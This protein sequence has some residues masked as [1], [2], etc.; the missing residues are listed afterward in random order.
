MKKLALYP[1]GLPL[2][3]VNEADPLA[4][5]DECTLC[6]LHD[7]VRRVCMGAEG[8]RGGILVV[9]ERPTKLEDTAG[10][11][12]YGQSGLRVR[13]MMEDM[14]EKAIPITYDYAIKCH[15]SALKMNDK[16][17][18]AC[19]SYMAYTLRKTKPTRI[20]CM[21]TEAALSVLGRRI[22]TAK[23]RRAYGW[24]HGKSGPIPVFVLPPPKL[25]FQNPFASKAFRQDL[26]WALEADVKPWFIDAVTCL[27]RTKADARVAAKRL[28]RSAWYAYDVETYGRMHN[29]N[30]R[31]EAVTLL[32]H[33]ASKSYTWTREALKDPGALSVLRDLMRDKRLRAATQNGK[34]DDRSMLC[35]LGVAPDIYYDTRLGRKLL[36]PEASASLDHLA[37]TVGMGGHKREAQAKN[38]I[39]KRELNRLANPPSELTPKG[40]RRKIKPPMF[41]VD[42]RVL[43]DIRG[44]IDPDAFMYGF[45]EDRVLYRY[46]ARDVWSTREVTVQDMPVLEKHPTISRAWNLVV[47]DANKAIRRIEH[48]GFPVD[49]DAVEHLASYC[50]QGIADLDDKMREYTDINPASTKQLAEYLYE[51]LDLPCQKM[52]PSGARST[53]EEALEEL[54]SSH[55]YVD[56]LLQRRKL[57]KFAGTYAR[58]MLVHICDDGRI[59]P[60]FLLDGAGTGRLSCQDP[61]LQNIPR[62]KGSALGTMARNC[63]V[64]SGNGWSLLELDFSQ[65]ELRIAAMLSGDTEMINDFKNG[66]DIHMNG[67]TL[68]CEVV[69]KIPRAKWDKMTDE[70]RAPHRSQIKTTIF[71]KLYG[72][73]DAGLAAEFGCHISVIAAI[74]KLIWGRYRKLAKFMDQCTREA[75]Q[76][77][78]TWTW[79]DGDRARV[80]PIWGIADQ[81]E[82]RRKHYDRTAGNTPVQGTAA[83]FMTASLWRVIEYIDENAVPAEVVTTVHD[84]IMINVKDSAIGEMAYH[85]DKIM[86]SHN[87]LGVPIKT[88]AQ[89]GP[90]WGSMKKLE[91]AA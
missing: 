37:E 14:T 83:E 74:N 25:A 9:G 46:N 82:K 54:K 22:H 13:K 4:Y 84:S 86:R 67:A 15:T 59:H 89:V 16:W 63:F 50:D 58:G 5:D 78:M 73:T 45:L 11:V 62:A 27:V 79:W 29:E 60:S 57:A 32:G 49:R 35:F 33:G 41:D 21:G 7:G 36:T 48:W 12:F 19:R 24:V 18:A 75:R 17:F 88:D 70:E 28:R 76:T 51:E 52:T 90:A 55:P 44:G 80:R 30:F 68:C 56:L 40:N 71:G 42:D 8:E 81:D 85:A 87:S 72:K 10:K 38:A 65:L 43:E 53:D 39:I 2:A 61:N 1:A 64:S 26:Q 66:I 3:A 6:P 91:A 34:Y 69:W 31:V 77:G 23:I 20:I 47:K